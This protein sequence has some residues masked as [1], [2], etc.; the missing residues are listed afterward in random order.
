[1]S[2]SEQLTKDILARQIKERYDRLAPF[3]NEKQRR[4]FAGAEALS[5]GVG[6][7]KRV[8]TVLAM[9]PNTVSRGMKEVQDPEATDAERVRL[10]GGGRK[11]ATELDPELLDDLERLIAPETRGDPQSHLRW[12]CK[13]TRKLAAELEAMKPGRAVSANLVSR[14][15]REQG[16]SLQANRKTLEGAEHPD[17]DAQFQMI[18]QMVTEYQEREQPV[19]SV[20]TKK[21]ELVGDFK[22]PGSE[23]QPMGR[24]LFVRTYDFVLLELG[25]ANPYGVYDRTRNE[26]WVNVGVD[27]DTAEFAV[28]SIHGWWK[29]MGKD[30]YPNATELLITADGGGSNSSRSRLWKVE[31]Q[32]FADDSGLSVGV[33]HYPPG[34]SKWN[35]I[36]HRMFSHITQ[37]WRGRPLVSHETIVI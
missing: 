3:L 32:K 6:G 9:S 18:N 35:A 27:H 15:L 16:Y 17:R 21:K 24:P 8:A 26:G 28:A 2:H 20:D 29:Q 1:M 22:N 31:L 33:C 37:N 34:T 30:A 7:L 11:L 5:Y 25:K 13:S 10:S 19:I 23:W 4:L 36:E 12:T 14:L